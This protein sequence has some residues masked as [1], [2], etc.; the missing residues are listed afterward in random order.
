M[1]KSA[2]KQRRSTL[3]LD[4]ALNGQRVCLAGSGRYGVVS[5]A[6]TWVAHDP[7]KRPR[8]QTA[9]KW[10]R[11]ECSLR[12]GALTGGYQ[13][14][15]DPRPVKQGDEITIRVLG[16]GLSELP[17]YRSRAMRPRTNVGKAKQ[18]ILEDGGESAARWGESKPDEIKPA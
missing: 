1:P 8:S 11:G 2:K 17:P 15:W 7:R 14:S 18:P 6:L 16:A 13:E 3:R 4:V 10:D 9:A 12:I 5:L